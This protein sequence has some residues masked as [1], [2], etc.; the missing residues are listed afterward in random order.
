MR[1][2]DPYFSKLIRIMATRCMTTALYF[3]SGEAAEPEYYHYGLAAPIYTHFTSPIRRYADVVVHR[4]LMAALGLAPLPGAARDRARVAATVDNLNL[5]HRNA[6][7]AGRASVE[8][9]TLIF[10]RG[11]T[12]LADARVVKVRANGLLVF[13]PKYGIEGPVHWDDDGA[14]AKLVYDE[15][16]QHVAA[17][18]GSLAYTIFDA[19]AVTISVEEGFANRRTLRLRLADRATLPEA[20][21]MG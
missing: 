12:V 8:L 17:A 13:V 16:R 10:F 18:D 7:L 6:Q 4:V 15:D 11:K 21:R 2:S 5:R 14:G 1:P 20:E 3:S 9:H 19:C